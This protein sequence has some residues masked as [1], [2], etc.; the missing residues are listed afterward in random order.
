ME[1]AKARQREQLLE[2]EEAKAKGK[3]RARAEEADAPLKRRKGA[4]GSVDSNVEVDKNENSKNISDSPILKQPSLITGAKMKDFQLEGL[5]W[6][7]SLHANGIS[8]I[9]GASTDSINWHILLITRSIA[10]EM[11]LGKVRR[12]SNPYL[13]NSLLIT[14]GR[15]SKQSRLPLIFEK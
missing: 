13:R 6:M 14:T 5:Q 2:E 3:K 7:I 10:D 9:L 1:T 8:G 15:L 12:A 4:E 11:G